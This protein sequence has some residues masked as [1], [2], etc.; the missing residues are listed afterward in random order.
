MSAGF[1]VNFGVHDPNLVTAD[2]ITQEARAGGAWLTAVESESFIPAAAT[3]ARAL[4]AAYPSGPYRVSI[5]VR[6]NLGISGEVSELS[7]VVSSA[8]TITPKD[9]PADLASSTV[10]AAPSEGSDPGQ[11]SPTAGEATEQSTPIAE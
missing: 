8:T 10:D 5:S 4:M 1:V 3:A 7:V 6:D 9:S 11:S 2:L